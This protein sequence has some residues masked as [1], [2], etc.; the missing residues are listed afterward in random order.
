[1][2]ALV[3]VAVGF[4]GLVLMVRLLSQADYG[5]FGVALIAILAGEMLAGGVM[6]TALEQRARLERAHAVSVFW[7][8]LLL[9]GVISLTVLLLAG[10]ISQLL[11]G[12]EAAGIIRAATVLTLMSAAAAVPM[13]LMRRAHRFK[14]IARIEMIMNVS[15]VCV[16]VT[17]AFAGLGAWALLWMEAARR[18]VRLVLL[19]VASDWR[20]AWQLS[21]R[22]FRE[23]MPFNGAVLTGSLIGQSDR[24]A[25]QIAAVTLFGP[26]ALGLYMV[27]NRF[28]DQVQTLFVNPAASMALPVLSRLQDEP[29]R[30]HEMMKAA[31]RWAAMT[32]VPALMGVAAI[33]PLLMPLLAGERWTGLAL[34]VMLIVPAK[35]RIAAS[36]VNLASLQAVGRPG[37]ATLSLTASFLVH[38]LALGLLA[39]FGL[40]AIAAAGLI[41]AVLSWPVASWLVQRATGL[42]IWAQWRSLAAGLAASLVMFAFVSL[43]VAGP[44]AGLPAIL[45]LVPAI[46]A[47]LVGFVGLLVILDRTAVPTLAAIAR[48]ATSQRSRQTWGHS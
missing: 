39:P 11:S 38:L 25:P 28:A 40:A 10:P 9:A 27:A 33:A 19:F 44:L 37:L 29:A 41:R 34:L 24:W 45:A 5:I 14:S 17:A 22:H 35:V 1:M 8:N 47:G 3:Q 7:V 13:A 48:A 42:S 18:A 21:W 32:G 43:L 36:T 26:E 4:I 23:L 31:W 30:L 12:P 46:L 2:A 16:G 15:A 6:A 20:P